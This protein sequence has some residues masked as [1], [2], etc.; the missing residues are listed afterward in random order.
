MMNPPLITFA[1]VPPTA[2]SRPALAVKLP[3]ASCERPGL[4]PGETAE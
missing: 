3:A 4:L 1:F 2:D